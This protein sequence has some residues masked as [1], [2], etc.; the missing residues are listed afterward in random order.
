MSSIAWTEEGI[1]IHDGLNVLTKSPI[2]YPYFKDHFSHTIDFLNEATL[3]FN[4]DENPHQW[5]LL[6]SH[7]LNFIDYYKPKLQLSDKQTV[8]R[9]DW[10]SVTIS[11]VLVIIEHYKWKMSVNMDILKP[12]DRY[13]D[14]DKDAYIHQYFENQKEV[15]DRQLQYLTRDFIEKVSFQDRNVAETFKNKMN[16]KA[17]VERVTL[18]TDTIRLIKWKPDKLE[19]YRD[20]L[21]DIDINIIN[22]SIELKQTDIRAYILFNL[23]FLEKRYAL[24]C[25]G[26]RIITDKEA[27]SERSLIDKET[28]IEL[29][30]HGNSWAIITCSLP[31]STFNDFM[32]NKEWF[33][34]LKKEIQK[35]YDELYSE[36]ATLKEKLK[37]LTE[38]IEKQMQDF[39]KIEFYV[40][41]KNRDIG[42][43]K[44]IVTVNDPKNFQ[45]TDQRLWW[46][47]EE[48]FDKVRK[49]KTFEK[50]R[51]IS[52]L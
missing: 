39:W 29:Y 31:F 36:K 3:T 52:D 1:S 18:V 30:E 10:N 25:S 27:I 46:A 33:E 41:T 19:E 22:Y 5:S 45:K 35:D 13:G 43:V 12:N 24:F 37:K 4:Y 8:V 38:H 26:E 15:Y 14:Q 44:D 7:Y 21:F 50:R 40:G 51:K 16:S 17:W 42:F 47:D 20:L 9:K 34:T 11:I 28:M 23:I 2:S 6:Y 49:V 32:T 48:T